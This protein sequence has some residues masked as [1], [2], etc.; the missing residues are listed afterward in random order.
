MFVNLLHYFPLIFHTHVDQHCFQIFSHILTYIQRHPIEKKKCIRK[1]KSYSKI[2]TL[3]SPCHL[4]YSHTVDRIVNSTFSIAIANGFQWRPECSW[5]PYLHNKI[6]LSMSDG[7]VQ[8][9]YFIC[10]NITGSSSTKFMR[11]WGGYITGRQLCPLRAY[12]CMSCIR[13]YIYMQN[14]YT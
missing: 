12:I 14:I 5:L 1:I 2:R 3:K 10:E 9:H 13:I 4:F 8:K 6:T 11:R 7:D